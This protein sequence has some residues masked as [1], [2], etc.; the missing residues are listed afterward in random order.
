[1]FSKRLFL[2]P[3]CNVRLFHRYEWLSEG[4]GGSIPPDQDVLLWD[5]SLD[6]FRPVSFYVK[7]AGVYE[8]I[9]NSAVYEGSVKSLTLHELCAVID[10]FFCAILT[11]ST[12]R[13]T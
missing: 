12:I 1:M 3:N 4:S 8:R 11:L 2:P 10:E 9:I 6:P 13:I 5:R 7:L